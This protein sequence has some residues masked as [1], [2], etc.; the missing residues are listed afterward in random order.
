MN[1]GS[2]RCARQAGWEKQ[3]GR[4]QKARQAGRANRTS[5]Q[6]GKAGCQADGYSSHAN[7]EAGMLAEKTD[8]QARKV[9]KAGTQGKQKVTLGQAGS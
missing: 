4:A 2:S 1:A 9:S 7:K 6:A 8:A 5:T 3:E